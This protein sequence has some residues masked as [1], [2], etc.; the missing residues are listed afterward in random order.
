MELKHSVKMNIIPKYFFLI[1]FLFLPSILLGSN[2]NANPPSAAISDDSIFSTPTNPIN[3]E[4]IDR[5]ILQ[6]KMA[7]LN[8][9]SVLELI[10]KLNKAGTVERDNAQFKKALTIHF[11]SLQISE[12][13]KDTFGEIV[14]LNN[15]GTDLRRTSAYVEAS[16]YH[17]K[18]L[19]LAKKN[20]NYLKSQAVALNGLGNIFI[21]LNKLDEAKIFFEK[22][23]SI[24][25]TLNST[26][27][28]AINY[29]NIGSVFFEKNQQDSALK[30]YNKSLYLNKSIK[31]DLG[32]SLCQTAI[33]SIYL[34]KGKINLGL[35]LIG[36]AINSRKNSED[37]FHNI[38]MQITYCKALMSLNQLEKADQQI[39]EIVHT[40][41]A[42]NSSEH[43]YIAYDLL[44]DI[45]KKQGR[46]SE[47]LEAKELATKYLEKSN[48]LSNEVKI[49]EIENRY[50]NKE[51]LQQIKLLTTE[52]EL[53][54]KGKAF[55]IR[56]FIVITLLMLILA[57]FLYMLNRRRKQLNSELRKV[58]EM[59][60]KFFSNV[61]HEFRTPLSLIK[62]PVEKMLNTNLDS[63][64]TPDLEMINRNVNHL[65]F[66]VNQIMNS[67][68]IEAGKFE[69]KCSKDDLSQLI[70]VL[71]QSFLHQATTNTINYQVD[72]QESG[73]VWY[74]S[75]IVKI[76]M[77]NLLSNAFK[78]TPTSGNIS[79]S[80]KMV[81]NYYEIKIANSCQNLTNEQLSKIF[82]RFYSNDSS[83]QPGTGIGLSLVKELCTLYR[84]KYSVRKNQ[85]NEFEFVLL[86]PICKENF[87]PN[88][89][90]E[91][92]ESKQEYFDKQKEEIRSTT[93]FKKT[94]K[95]NI[96]LPLLLLVDD[97]D[98][99]RKYLSGCFEN[100]CNVI[101]ASDGKE[102]IA[103]AIELIPD[104]IVSDVMMPNINGIELC[105]TLKNDYTTNHIP[106]ILLS[107][108]DEEENMLN[109][110]VNKADDYVTKPFNAKIL[111][112]KVQN[113][114]ETRNLLREK[115]RK[116]IVLKPYNLLLQNKENKFAEILKDILEKHICN[117][118]FDV[119]EFCKIA[120]MSRTQLH[121]KLKAISD[122]SASTFIRV[123]RVKIASE[124][125][126]NAD[127]NIA[128]VCY[129]AGFNDTSYFSKSF[130][131]VFG[132]SP[133]EYR[134]SHF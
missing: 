30:Y 117:P 14:A 56:I 13:V 108:L 98:D 60:S 76:L 19:D 106:I 66:L 53:V 43:Q 26:L 113:L 57:G 88:E 107:A 102:G 32:I 112:T 93:D 41:N 69:I 25:K 120:G 126:K 111:I 71:S 3:Y 45:R 129:S 39:E 101:E 9:D 29:A 16:T 6:K 103:K 121:R 46:F 100:I 70:N 67:A 119:E 18:A 44:T 8:R 65:L 115:Y 63:E 2:E 116:E 38:E 17:Y 80:T 20:K 79:L 104:I 55:Q 123:H 122:M 48:I 124:L 82:D 23:I 33:G 7:E 28:Q 131:E 128:D 84:A 109:G 54:E 86:L 133:V 27:G 15:L 62:G 10:K 50:K 42:I 95:D 64:N 114:I 1:S 97:N 40:A 72:I 58:N 74:D 105:N 91:F 5:F 85:K 99:M 36:D 12:Q 94:K 134:K 49:I 89:I 11:Q 73:L 35:K 90:K 47:A 24:E 51:S 59:K 31:S 81:D 22:A 21:S 87:K 125:L 130:K 78:F 127:L 118:D 4:V 83:F 132:V 110:L 75:E 52:K 37:A 61:S 92:T 34:K 77:N 68:K 96:E